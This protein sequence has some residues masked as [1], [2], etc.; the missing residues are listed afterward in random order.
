MTK[1]INLSISKSHLVSQELSLYGGELPELRLERL[2][3]RT[4]LP[5][6]LPPHDRGFSVPGIK[7]VVKSDVMTVTYVKNDSYI[8]Q[9]D[10]IIP[11]TN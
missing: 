4:R 1:T 5:Q 3:H 8:C 11:A 2:Q 7:V 9:E 10:N 6:R